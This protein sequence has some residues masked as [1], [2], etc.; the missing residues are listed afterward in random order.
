MITM[1]DTPK[2]VSVIIGMLE[3]EARLGVK[4]TKI[5]V[6]RGSNF[7]VENLDPTLVDSTIARGQEGQRLFGL[8]GS[9]TSQRD[10]QWSNYAE[11]AVKLVK[12][13]YKKIFSLAPQE[14]LPILSRAEHSYLAALVSQEINSIPYLVDT[15]EKYFL[16]P[17]DFI[18]PAQY[19][20]ILGNVDSQVPLVEEVCDRLVAYRDMLN[21]VMMD[22]YR[23]RV[24]R[25]KHSINPQG[26]K[27]ASKQQIEV[28][29]L[30]LMIRP[31]YG[32]VD[33]GLVLDV[34]ETQAQL[35]FRNGSMEWHSIANLVPLTKESRAKELKL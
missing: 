30:V 28:G 9:H 22:T 21:Q 19:K 15:G 12:G 10:S 27:S 3:I 1:M 24:N 4:I 13:F 7:L 14:A 8:L 25:L 35:K 33:S 5:S 34:N 17:G 29:G 11:S 6:D 31:K 26:M 23:S 16:S 20:G 18:Y 2:T 32:L